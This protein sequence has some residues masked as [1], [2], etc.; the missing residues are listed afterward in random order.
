[1]VTCSFN[2]FDDKFLVEI[3]HVQSLKA[4][5]IQGYLPGNVLNWTDPGLVGVFIYSVHKETQYVHF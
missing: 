5:L 4:L 1:M 3:I 2:S